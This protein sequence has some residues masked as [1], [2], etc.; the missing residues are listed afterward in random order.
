[1][2]A[3]ENNAVQARRGHTHRDQASLDASWT[4]FVT[5]WNMETSLRQLV[6][7]REVEGVIMESLSCVST[8]ASCLG[9]LIETV[10]SSI[11]VKS[12]EGASQI[13]WQSPI[14]LGGVIC[15]P[16]IR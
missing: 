13:K 2:A 10:A 12:A 1:M 11:T 8:S 6:E 14:T 3:M 4:A 7:R 16:G 15:L 5:R 9:I